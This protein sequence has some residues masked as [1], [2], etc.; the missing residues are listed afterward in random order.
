M[1]KVEI[2]RFF[3]ENWEITLAIVFMT[4]AL[5]VYIEKRTKH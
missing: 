5:A 1:T 3:Y 2:I 4:I